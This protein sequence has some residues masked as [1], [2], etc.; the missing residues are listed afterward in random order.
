MVM[1][2]AVGGLLSGVRGAG[3]RSIKADGDGL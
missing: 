3:A 1:G 2:Y